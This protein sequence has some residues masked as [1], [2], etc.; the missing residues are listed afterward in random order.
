[1][2]IVRRTPVELE[3]RRL[4]QYTRDSLILWDTEGRVKAHAQ[5]L[6][7]LTPHGGFVLGYGDW[8]VRG[9]DGTFFPCKNEHLWEIYKPAEPSGPATVPVLADDQQPV[10]MDVVTKAC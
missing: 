2:K 1:M 8:L 10:G 9:W 6:D 7:I 4:T 3:A 5:G